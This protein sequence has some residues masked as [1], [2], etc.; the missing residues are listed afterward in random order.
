MTVAPLER[1]RCTLAD[2]AVFA[3]LSATELGAIIAASELIDLSPGQTLLAEGR[4]GEGL[5]V[6][7]EGAGPAAR[8]R[9]ARWRSVNARSS[10]RSN[11]LGRIGTPVSS[12]KLRYSGCSMV[13]ETKTMRRRRSGQRCSSSR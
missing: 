1:Y 5:Y 8:Y 9:S 6:I 13:P 12:R 10:S 11:G 2:S 3:G 4:K 7:L